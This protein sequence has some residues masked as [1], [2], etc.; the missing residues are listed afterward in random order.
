ME[1]RRSISDACIASNS[2]YDD[3]GL[4]GVHSNTLQD[5]PEAFL[6]RSVGLVQMSLDVLPGLLDL[7]LHLSGVLPVVSHE[8]QVD[9]LLPIPL[10]G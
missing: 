1:K 7:L 8:L 10:L 5:D 3:V 6:G 2:I 9:E 4:D